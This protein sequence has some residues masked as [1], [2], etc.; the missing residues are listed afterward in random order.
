[1][2]ATPA[3]QTPQ[4]QLTH[5]AATL[6]VLGSHASH[7]VEDSATHHCVDM[8]HIAHLTA[9]WGAQVDA[10]IAEDRERV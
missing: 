1:M 5:K 4:R 6:G 9:G 2:V 10:I 8:D 3:P 7:R